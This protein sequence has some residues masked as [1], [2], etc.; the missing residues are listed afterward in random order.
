MLSIEGLADYDIIP[1]RVGYLIRPSSPIFVHEGGIIRF[2]I[3]EGAGEWESS[4]S[5]VVSVDRETGRAIAHRVGSTEIVFKSGMMLRSR[6]N[7]VD[8]SNIVQADADKEIEYHGTSPF[9]M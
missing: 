9:N 2:T 3:Q 7:V 5:A 4:E 8:V 1:I 6:V